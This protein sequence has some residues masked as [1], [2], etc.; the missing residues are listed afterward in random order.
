MLRTAKTARAGRDRGSRGVGPKLFGHIG[1]Y[2]FFSLLSKFRGRREREAVHMLSTRLSILASMC[3][4][5]SQLFKRRKKLEIE[6]RRKL[7]KM[8]VFFNAEIDQSA[9]AFKCYLYQVVSSMIVNER[10]FCWGHAITVD[11]PISRNTDV[12]KRMIYEA[13][14]NVTQGL[15]NCGSQP[16]TAGSWLLF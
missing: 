6:V 12:H 10:F 13:S 2:T 4:G 3:A 11:D 1:I 8:S 14:A 16:A 7:W 5:L 15:M 9:S